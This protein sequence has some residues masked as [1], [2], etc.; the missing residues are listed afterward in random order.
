MKTIIMK[1]L[2][3]KSVMLLL[4]IVTVSLYNNNIHRCTWEDCHHYGQSVDVQTFTP[5]WGDEGT[6]AYYVEITH[7]AQPQWTYE[8]CVDYVFSGVE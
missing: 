1:I 2:V 5:I 6:D 7:V 3:F 4:I 8:Q